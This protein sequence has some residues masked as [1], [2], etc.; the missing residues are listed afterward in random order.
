MKV[1]VVKAAELGRFGRLDT[2]YFL[3]PPSGATERVA[4]LRASGVRFLR[5]GSG[6]LEA[7]VWAP[8]RF[9]RAYAAS[10]EE[11]VPYL[12]PHDVF[13][14]LPEPADVLSLSRT[15]QVDTY[16]IRRGMILQTC[17][18]RNLGPAVIADECLSRFV[19]SHDMIRIEVDDEVRRFYVLAYLKTST[20][21]TLLRRDK[22]GS[23]IDHITDQHV[24]DQE[25]PFLTDSVVEDLSRR[26]AEAFRIRERARLDLQALIAAFEAKLPPLKRADQLCSGWTVRASVLTGRLD[27][28]SYDPLVAVARREIEKVGAVRMRDVARVSVLGR[29]KRLYSDAGHGRPIISGDQLLQVEPIHLQYILP[30]S[31]DDVA[32]FELRA[33]WIAYPSDGRAEESLGTPVVITPERDGWLASNMVGRVVP[34]PGTDAG[35]LYL[36]LNSRHAQVQFKSTASGSV[37]DHT[38]PWDMEG[39]L[40][41]RVECDGD[42]VLRAWRAFGDAQTMEQAV[43]ADLDER[44]G[45]SSARS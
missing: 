39:V 41:P 12:R 8:S 16:R 17:S 6:G 27:A 33:G 43:I 3:A 18:G 29:Y 28:A 23:V 4:K 31:F 5:M 14:Y 22:T 13:N 9:K 25:V 19:L 30:A 32:T 38:Y 34:N 42:A 2:K 45:A 44:L 11:S 37:I 7:R 36:A 15:E 20:G 26:M 1:Q 21:Q 10:D 35:W 24:A 40:L